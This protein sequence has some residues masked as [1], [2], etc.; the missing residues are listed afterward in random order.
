M[1]IGVILERRPFNLNPFSVMSPELQEHIRR[2]IEA[3]NQSQQDQTSAYDFEKSF[4]ETW[5]RL[6]Q[7]VFQEHMGPV[8]KSRNQK[9][10]QDKS[11]LA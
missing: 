5:M 9:K 6:G 11:R 7:E 10:D 3:W 1:R 2:E 4:V 8:P